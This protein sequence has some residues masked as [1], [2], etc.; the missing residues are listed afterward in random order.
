MLSKGA[1]E[2]AQRIQGDTWMDPVR[3]HEYK[4]QPLNSKSDW[5]KQ[6]LGE[7]EC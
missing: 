1:F 2:V 3:E 4:D 7:N 6:L 5:K